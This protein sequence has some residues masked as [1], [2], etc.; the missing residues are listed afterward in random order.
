MKL[1]TLSV[2]DCEAK[3]LSAMVMDHPTVSA[4]SEAL[5]PIEGLV[6]L[7]FFGRYRM[8]IDYQ[9]KEMTF[10]PNQFEPPDMIEELTKNLMLPNGPAKKC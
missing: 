9:A 10:T 8:T 1:K 7:S 3:N 5:G 4:I 6:G 2:G